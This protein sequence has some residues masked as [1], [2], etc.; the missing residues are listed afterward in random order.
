M[1]GVMMK[2]FRWFQKVPA[3]PSVNSQRTGQRPVSTKKKPGGKDPMGRPPVAAATD[4]MRQAR[5]AAAIAEAEVV[6]ISRKHLGT[7]M[8]SSPRQRIA[9]LADPELTTVDRT[10][11]EHSV[12]SALPRSAP[13]NASQSSLPSYFR[14]LLRTCGY[15]CAV[16]TVLLAAGGLLAG[17]AWHNTADRIVGTNFTWMIDWHLPNRSIWRGAWKAG[18]P[19]IAMRPHNGKVVLRYWLNGLGYA[20]TEVD[21]S[22]LRGNSFDYV[23]APTGGTGAVSPASR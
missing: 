4:P 12:R 5:H 3:R 9:H 15:K 7:L 13:V 17:M 2:L 10:E 19:M 1:A 16:A 11:L 22:W 21:E 20:T 18:L 14:R 6:K 8:A 23:V